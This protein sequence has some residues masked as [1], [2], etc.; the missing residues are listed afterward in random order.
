MTP[1]KEIAADAK[2]LPAELRTGALTLE[3]GRH[4]IDAFAEATERL[5]SGEAIG[6][7][8]LDLG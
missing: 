1:G 4:G 5:R 6:K 3:I 7:V 8:V 2:G